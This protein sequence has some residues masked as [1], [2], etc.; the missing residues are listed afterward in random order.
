M[1]NSTQLNSM[2]DNRITIGPFQQDHVRHGY[3]I[4]RKYSNNDHYYLNHRKKNQTSLKL[5]AFRRMEGQYFSSKV[6]LL[7]HERNFIKATSYKAMY[8]HL[9]K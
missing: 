8:F 7:Y 5:I 9:M 1:F 4:L 2:L 3:R 6:D